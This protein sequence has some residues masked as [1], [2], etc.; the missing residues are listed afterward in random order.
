MDQS[1]YNTSFDLNNVFAYQKNTLPK[2]IGVP[3]INKEFK[4]FALHYFPDK[5]ARQLRSDQNAA[6]I[7][8]CVV[9][10]CKSTA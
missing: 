6:S 8:P 4:I 7:Q 9:C 10:W 5:A 1:P 2:N 3:E